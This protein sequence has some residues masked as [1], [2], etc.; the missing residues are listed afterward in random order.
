MTTTSSPSLEYATSGHSHVRAVVHRPATA[1]TA[2]PRSTRT[3]VTVA[4]VGVAIATVAAALAFAALT[5]GV[6]PASAA[7]TVVTPAPQQPA[8]HGH[9]PLPVLHLPTVPARQA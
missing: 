5:L 2:S 3:A 6:H 8:M 9:G 4:L 7:H 1:S